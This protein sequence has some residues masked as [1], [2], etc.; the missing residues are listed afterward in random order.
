MGS[1]E[2]SKSDIKDRLEGRLIQTGEGTTSIDRLKVC[3]SNPPNQESGFH[4]V[5][6]LF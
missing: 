6:V 3:G 1:I 5:D 2:P 4:I